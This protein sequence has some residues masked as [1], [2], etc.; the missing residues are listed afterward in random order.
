MMRFFLPAFTED[1]VCFRIYTINNENSDGY[2]IDHSSA[3][4]NTAYLLPD[5][6]TNHKKDS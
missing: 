6:K 1:T 3:A 4:S 2:K 5:I